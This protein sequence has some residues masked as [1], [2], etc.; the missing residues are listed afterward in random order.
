MKTK[1]IFKC[2]N[3]HKSWIKVYGKSEIV[4]PGKC[5][6]CGKKNQLIRKEICYVEKTIIID[7]TEDNSRRSRKTN[8]KEIKTLIKKAIEEI[9]EK[10]ELREVDNGVEFRVP[11]KGE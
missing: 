6:I 4:Y 3:G 5:P 11:K 2:P 9:E 8:K 1:Y 7:Y 10:S